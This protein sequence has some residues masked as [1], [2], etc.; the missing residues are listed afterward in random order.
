MTAVATKSLFSEPLQ[1]VDRV[2]VQYQGRKLLYFG[3]CDYHR[4]SSDAAVVLAVTR[5]LHKYGLNVAAS[6]K[7][8][9]NHPLYEQL[10]VDLA[11]F[12]R[13]QSALLTPNG[14]STNLALAQGLAGRVQRAFIDERAHPSLQ[15]AAVL[16]GCRITPFK[17][18]SGIE[19]QKQL[20]RETAPIAVLTDGL[21]AHSGAVAPLGQY[22]TMLPPTGFLWV[23]DSH[24]VGVLGKSGR[25]AC[26]DL[27][28][29]DPRLVQTATL[30]KA[31]G[32]YGGVIL[33]NREVIKE[34]AAK[35]RLLTG[36]TP[37]PLPLVGGVQKSLQK[38]KSPILSNRLR[39]RSQW[40]ENQLGFPRYPSSPIFSLSLPR[41]ATASLRRTLL[42][43]GIYPPLIRYPGGAEEGFFRFALSSAHTL[44]QVRRLA[45]CLKVHLPPDGWF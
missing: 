33:G 29:G 23:D 5:A 7:T 17:H 45:E 22:Y 3:G 14:Y 19:L 1:Q 40:L 20:D 18:A 27:D 10:E 11:R 30:S 35:S 4:L 38:L 12:F 41:K 8:T 42:R 21:F 24:G 6:R 34:T 37:L 15:D 28:P 39:L 43:S 9:G 13:V 32:V 44:Q 36:S 16:L 2:F 26:E 25:G 31:F